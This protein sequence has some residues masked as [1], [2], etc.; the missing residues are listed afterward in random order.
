MMCFI[1]ANENLHETCCLSM[2]I[3]GGRPLPYGSKTD[4][5]KFLCNALN[6]IDIWLQTF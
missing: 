4:A 6:F 1:N 2:S 5:L 3:G